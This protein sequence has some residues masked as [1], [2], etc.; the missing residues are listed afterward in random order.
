MPTARRVD[1]LLDRKYGAAK[2]EFER[3]NHLQNAAQDAI[4]IRM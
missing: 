1:E 3:R 2:A 4:E